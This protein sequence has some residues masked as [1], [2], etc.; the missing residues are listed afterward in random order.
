MG[1]RRTIYDKLERHRHL[2]RFQPPTAACLS[3]TLPARSLE[4]QSPSYF[5]SA[6]D[7]PDHTQPTAPSSWCPAA[8]GGR[9]EQRA[10]F[11]KWLDS[12]DIVAVTV[13][14]LSHPLGSDPANNPNSQYW[15]T[16][17][18]DAVPLKAWAEASAGGPPYDWGTGL[19]V[20]HT[21]GTNFA[22]TQGHHPIRKGPQGGTPK[23]RRSRSSPRCGSTARALVTHPEAA[24]VWLF[25]AGRGP[26]HRSATASTPPAPAPSSTPRSSA[27]NPY[28]S[29]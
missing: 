6:F 12:A 20:S 17:D 16:D 14:K 2:C 25:F 3:A 15:F 19:G 26:R 5:H 21:K 1:H 13:G 11:E 28:R 23:R 27:V 22:F 8:T 4:H 10:T 7:I 18:R 24:E 29:T 9:C